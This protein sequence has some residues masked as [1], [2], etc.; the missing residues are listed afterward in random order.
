M[1][2]DEDELD[3]DGK[4]T[5]RFASRKPLYRT[6]VVSVYWHPNRNSSAHLMQVNELLAAVDAVADPEPSTRYTV[7]VSGEVIDVPPKTAQKLENRVRRWMVCPEWLAEADNT[8]YDVPNR[9]VDSGKAWGDEVDPEELEERQ[10]KFKEE[11]AGV[12]KKK[13]QVLAEKKKQVEAKGAA[14]EREKELREKRKAGKAAEQVSRSKK[15]KVVIPDEDD[16]DADQT[17]GAGPSET[18]RDDDD[19][20]WA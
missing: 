7:R 12:V 14:K 19:D 4:R 15:R 18:H 9:I 10:K 8:K 17:P 20:F 16:M 3:A 5:G 11:K 6:P 13:K 2:D 1:S